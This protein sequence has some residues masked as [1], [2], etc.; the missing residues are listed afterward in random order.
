MVQINRYSKIGIFLIVLAILIVGCQP[1]APPPK[2]PAPTPVQP[3]VIVPKAVE[4]P[5]EAPIQPVPAM[6]EKAPSM[7]SEIVQS[8]ITDTNNIGAIDDTETTGELDNL[9]A[10]LEKI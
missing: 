10:F 7:Q 3:S 8:E 2:A 6:E 9:D 5:V 4:K 1:T